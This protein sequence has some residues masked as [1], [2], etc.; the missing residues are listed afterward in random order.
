MTAVSRADINTH[1]TRSSLFY[2]VAP[3][4]AAELEGS[5]STS[6]KWSTYLPPY[7][8]K[9]T[10]TFTQPAPNDLFRDICSLIELPYFPWAAFDFRKYPKVR[11]AAY[12]H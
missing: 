12:A 11:V 3:P 7:V 2:A 8:Q 6:F 1:S 10:A 5:H 9:R 4:K